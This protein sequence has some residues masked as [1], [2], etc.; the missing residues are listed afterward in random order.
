M[1]RF[2]KRQK[3]EIMKLKCEH[4]SASEAG[5][6]IFQVMFEAKRDREDGPYILI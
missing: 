3:G 2:I 5:D 1:K 4:T 6:E